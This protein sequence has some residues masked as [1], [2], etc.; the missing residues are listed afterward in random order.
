VIGGLFAAIAFELAKRGFGY[1]VRRIPTY[2]AVY[3]AFAALP[4]FL[5]WVYLS[6]FIA[7]LGA[8]VASALPAIR[9][10]QFHRIHYPGSDL[11]DALEL[12]ARL[13]EAHEVGKAGY[14]ATRLATMLRCDMETAQRLLLTMEEREW[15]ARLDG[16]EVGPRYILLANP[17]RLTLAQLFDVL[18]IDRTE[19][20][21]QLQRRRSHVD[22]AALLD[23][24]T[25]DRFDVSLASLIAA[26]R[27]TGAQPEESVPGPVPGAAPDPHARPPKT[28]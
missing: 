17:A 4:V 16:G 6:W 7:L 2:T 27:L 1:Y 13:A 22:G 21:Y 20:T 19:L 14:T 23:V 9:V 15:I 5:L 3:G 8:M 28:A 12:L 10:G 26:H 25:N 24:L 11:L 18:V